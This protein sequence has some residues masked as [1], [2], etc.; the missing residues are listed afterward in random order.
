MAIE[1]STMLIMELISFLQT[2]TTLRDQL[3]S[4]LEI[5]SCI[6]SILCGSSFPGSHSI[7]LFTALLAGAGMCTSS[8]PPQATEYILAKPLPHVLNLQFDNATRDNKNRFVIAFSSLLT[9]NG[10]FQEGYINFLI[11]G[12]THDDIDA[13][14]SR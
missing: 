2:Q 14:F 9:H 1:T 11:V 12:H 5:L 10:V 6:P 13:L 7:P 3:Q 8:P 4:Y